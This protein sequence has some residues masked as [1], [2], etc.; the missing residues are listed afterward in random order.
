MTPRVPGHWLLAIGR[1]LFD[2]TVYNAAVV[3]AIADFQAEW[4]AATTPRARLLARCRGLLAFASLLVVSPIAFRAWPGRE[5][6]DGAPLVTLA[7]LAVA[8]I[9]LWQWWIPI[10]Q[11]MEEWLGRIG[12]PPLPA[13]AWAAVLVGPALVGA[14]V[15]MRKHAP[16]GDATVAPVLLPVALLSVAI[17]LALGAAAV[18]NT[19]SPIGKTGSAGLGLVMGAVRAATMPAVYALLAAGLSLLVVAKLAFQPEAGMNR[20]VLSRSAAVTLTVFSAVCL[21][22][23]HVVME[24]QHRVMRALQLLL[25]P[26]NELPAGRTSLSIAGESEY[27]VHLMVAAVVLTLILAVVGITTWRALRDR[28]PPTWFL[29]ASRAAVI[30]ALVGAAWHTTITYADMQKLVQLDQRHLRK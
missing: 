2:R 4:L 25:T 24:L 23:S 11:P 21:A 30:V 8:G 17:P 19:F 3:P 26:F 20:P 6:G 7:V 15:L 16:D 18:I 27:V 1:A 28:R 22:G 9:A 10:G 5:R 29:W 13:A 12:R 14:Y